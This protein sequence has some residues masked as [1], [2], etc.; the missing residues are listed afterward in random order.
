MTRL[1][2]ISVQL[3]QD[4]QRAILVSDDGDLSLQ[5]VLPHFLQKVPSRPA[6]GC[7]P[8]A[9]AMTRNG[10]GTFWVGAQCW[11]A[12][13]YAFSVYR[14]P[15]PDGL[16]I[17][18]LCRNR[19]CVNPE[20]LEAVTQ[21]TNLARGDGLVS[22]QNARTHCPRGHALVPGNLDLTQVKAGKRSC[23]R[24]KADAQ[25]ARY[26]RTKPGSDVIEVTLPEWLAT[27]RRLV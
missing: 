19:R 6:E 21:S 7:W 9:G 20:H 2:D 10:Y 16:V 18:H 27:E 24:C 8:W 17:D 26:H 22:A 25:R 23:K 14:G 3:H 15:I 13:R 1:T 12:H 5:R 11:R 4:T